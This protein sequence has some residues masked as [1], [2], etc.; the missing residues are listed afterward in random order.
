MAETVFHAL[1]DQGVFDTY[2]KLVDYAARRIPFPEEALNEVNTS[3]LGI[4]LIQS[5]MNPMPL[6]RLTAE[7]A[8]KHPWLTTEEDNKSNGDDAESVQDT[9]VL[10]IFTPQCEDITQ[11]A[12][13]WTSD[14][15]TARLKVPSD[16]PVKFDQI[17]RPVEDRDRTC[18]PQESSTTTTHV[19]D[20]KKHQAYVE[21]ADED[22]SSV[23]CDSTFIQKLPADVATASL[24]QHSNEGSTENLPDE[25]EQR[26]TEAEPHD[27][28]NSSVEAVAPSSMTRILDFPRP[29]SSKPKVSKP[30]HHR[31]SKF[32]KDTQD[33]DPEHMRRQG[34]TSAQKLRPRTTL[35]KGRRKP[36]RTRTENED[37]VDHSPSQREDIISSVSSRAV[38]Q[39]DRP[40]SKSKT[41]PEHDI[42]PKEARPISPALDDNGIGRG[43]KITNIRSKIVSKHILVNELDYSYK[44][45]VSL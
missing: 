39:T 28:D 9:T 32:K 13:N 20:S 29:R 11:P 1:T 3:E 33:Q 34:E 6:E 26:E 7:L 42:V 40:T 31:T 22:S 44:D 37:Q 18:L 43:K 45:F 10:T 41:N 27:E 12:T 21:D 17:E 15:E 30:I 25:Q 23:A 36:A 4:D 24:V 8:L 5:M 19:V 35:P 2:L 16:L 14:I 38:L